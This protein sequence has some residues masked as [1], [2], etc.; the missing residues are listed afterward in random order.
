MIPQIIMISIKYVLIVGLFQNRQIEIFVNISVSPFNF[1]NMS[2]K[3]IA[4]LAA[5]NVTMT[6]CAR[7]V[8]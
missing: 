5:S 4:N 6:R 8:M 1:A 7:T 2:S 3:Y